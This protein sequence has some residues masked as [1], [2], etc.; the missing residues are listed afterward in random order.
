MMSSRSSAF[1]LAVLRRILVLPAM[2]LLA[3]TASAEEVKDSAY[4]ALYHRY[5]RLYNTDSIDE[6]YK[7]SEQLQQSFMKRGDMLR[8]YKIRQNEIFFDAAHDDFYQAIKKANDLLD[9]MKHNKVKHYELP[10]MSLGYIFETRGTYRIAVHYY[11][12]ALNNIEVKDSTGRAHVY[13]QLA[14]VNLTRNAAKA[15]EWNERLGDIISNDSLYYKQYL[16]NKSQIYFFNEDKENFFNVKRE[17]DNFSKKKALLDH[18]GEQLLK[19]MEKAFMGK[20]DEALQLLE[21]ESQDYDDIRRCD[22]RI[23]IY[24]MMGHS[25]WA[26]KETDRRRVIRDSLNN[27]LLFNN[28]NEINAT[29]NVAKLNEKAAKDREAWQIAVIILLLIAF[30]AAV[31]RYIT[32]RYY[33]RE[34]KKQNEEL[35]IVLD[36]AKESDRMKDFFIK[37]ISHEIRTP[38]NIITGYAQVI[39]NPLFDLDEKERDR[40][41]QAIGHNTGAITDIVND[42]LEIA[43]GESKERYRRNDRIAVNDFGR[44]L[45]EETEKKNEG[46]LKLCFQTNLPDGFTIQSSRTGIERIVLQLLNNSLKFTEQGQ[47][48]LS[49]HKNVDD[50]TMVF[51]V[52]DTGIGIPEEEQEQVFEHFYKLDSFKQGLGIGLSMSRRIAILLGGNLNID[53]SYHNGTRMVLTIP[54]Q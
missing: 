13:S 32:N 7:A 31:Y 34:I 51:A 54:L 12:E 45:M 20:Y 35:E 10:Y 19:A 11:E 21:Q 38:L 6:F 14:S 26:L 33:E 15:W 42:L 49:V 2:L 1:H 3:F 8:Y 25:D 5:Y 37:H 24:R 43:Q 18:N 39:T 50:N 46:R 44:Q 48:E 40:M 9:Y 47:V 28:L 41:V 23:Q 52:T 36:E 22:I 16:T 27:D 29:I 53:K 4:M 30:A 17:Y